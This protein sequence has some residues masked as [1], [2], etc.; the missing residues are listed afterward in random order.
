MWVFDACVPT[1]LRSVL[2][3]RKGLTKGHLMEFGWHM[4]QMCPC[5]MPSPTDGGTLGETL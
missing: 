5:G 2:K 1:R 4:K 3:C